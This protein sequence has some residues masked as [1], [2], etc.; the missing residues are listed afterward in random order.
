MNH[1]DRS[2]LT[3]DDWNL[4]TNIRN[5]YEEYCVQR[6]IDSHK[7][8]PLIPPKQPYRSRLKVQR[9]VD[10]KFKYMSVLASFTRRVLEFDRYTTPADNSYLYVKENVSC[11][12][13]TNACELMKSKALEF[14]PWDQDRL[15]LESILSESIIE[16]LSKALAGFRQLVPQDPIIIKLFLILLTLSPS[17]VPTDTKSEYQPLDFE[18]LPRNFLR[19]QSFYTDLLWKYI[20]HRLGYQSAVLIT[21]RFIQIFLHRQTVEANI[22][23]VISNRNDDGH[24][25]H[26]VEVPLTF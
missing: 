19:R 2:S 20:Q 23:D 8:V 10:L 13:T 7:T 21:A 22:R 24:L 11:L 4:L 1:R 6:F 14:A 26:L 16:N 15:A 18:P 9:L 25:S 17:I 3:L 5:A 12:I